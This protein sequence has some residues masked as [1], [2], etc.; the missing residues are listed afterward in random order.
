[1]NKY[2]ELLQTIEATD[3]PSCFTVHIDESWA[4]GRTTF[5]GLTASL[6]VHAIM[7]QVPEDR[8]LRN[9]AVNFV[10][11][12][13]VG[14]HEIRIRALREGGSVS[15]YQGEIV[16]DGNVT[17]T[18]TVAFG[19]SRASRFKFDGPSMPTVPSPLDLQSMPRHPGAP[20]FLQHFDLRFVA[21]A[22]PMSG[23]D[24]PDLALWIRF[25]EDVT[26]ST[27][28]M[29]AFA[30]VPPM[31]GLNMM[32]PP[33][34]GSSLSWYLEFPNYADAN[35]QWLYYDY[36]AQSAADGYFNNFATAWAEDGRP[37]LYSRQVAMLFEK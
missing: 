23:G 8:P 2:V 20:Q 27:P 12:V 18:L 16:C 37:L 32:R 19:K 15:H 9:L 4:Q 22:L 29:I 1:M 21:G 36:Q 30:D 25:N 34:A 3:Q 10:G 11:P 28:A 26:L 14:T 31:P 33:G 35:T 6:I 13:P 5:G 17:V 24:E 7:K